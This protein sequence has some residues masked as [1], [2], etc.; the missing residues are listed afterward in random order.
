[1]ITIEILFSK[2]ALEKIDG[3]G[4]DIDEV[5]N[6]ITKGMKWKEENS[7]K[8]HA[9]MAGIEYVF[10]KREDKLFVITV[11]ITKGEK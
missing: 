7:D 4:L 3:Y 8:W 1:M 2:H 9:N 5:E 10:I 6:V 11:Y